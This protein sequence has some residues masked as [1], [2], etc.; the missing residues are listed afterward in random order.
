LR[1][2]LGA[3]DLR[4]RR[5]CADR[6]EGISELQPG[7][8]ESADGVL[9]GAQ[10]RQRHEKGERRLCALVLIYAIDPEAVVTPHLLVDHLV[11]TP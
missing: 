2:A 3:G 7:L 4:R 5:W 8:V 11:L 9:H 1:L 10:F 6:R